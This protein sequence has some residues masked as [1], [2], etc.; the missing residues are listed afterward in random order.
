MRT[1]ISDNP[2]EQAQ[3]DDA[4]GLEY[5]YRK[6]YPYRSEDKQAYSLSLMYSRLNKGVMNEKADG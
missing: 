1:I 4:S 5:V 6:E 3:K 2:D